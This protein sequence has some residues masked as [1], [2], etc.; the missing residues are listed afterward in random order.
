[1]GV[2]FI[3][4]I[5]IKQKKNYLDDDDTEV[6]LKHFLQRGMRYKSGYDPK[7]KMWN[8]DRKIARDYFGRKRKSTGFIYLPGSKFREAGVH[9]TM[10]SCLQDDI[11][12]SASRIGKYI[13]KLEFYRQ[14]PPR[15]VKDKK[16]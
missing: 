16:Y 13:N 3:T 6:K 4:Y 15:R 5:K 7:H 11:I 8:R 12:N 2:G 10:R 9:L 14:W 1:M